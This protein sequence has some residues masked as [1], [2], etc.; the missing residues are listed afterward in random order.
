M[1]GDV[2]ILVLI[3]VEVTALESLVSKKVAVVPVVEEKQVLGVVSD[4]PDANMF[5]RLTWPSIF[6][7]LDMLQ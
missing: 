1:S 4:V 2:V 6:I 3:D 7:F 5:Y